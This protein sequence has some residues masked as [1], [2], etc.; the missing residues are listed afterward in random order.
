MISVISKQLLEAMLWNSSVVNIVYTGDTVK[1]MGNLCDVA[2][3]SFEYEEVTVYVIR[4]E[5]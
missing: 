4:K 2:V 1:K 3:I 5:K